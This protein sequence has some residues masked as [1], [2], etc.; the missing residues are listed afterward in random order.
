VTTLRAPDSCV[1]S[2]LACANLYSQSE[3][4]K[5]G[6]WTHSVP[7]SSAFQGYRE[8]EFV[9]G[10]S[11]VVLCRVAIEQTLGNPSTVG[12][13]EGVPIISVGQTEVAMAEG[14]K[15]EDIVIAV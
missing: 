5:L 15:M 10:G 3:P 4:R 14:V 6:N 11:L 9:I 13:S 7:P 1:S 12:V 2:F 8:S